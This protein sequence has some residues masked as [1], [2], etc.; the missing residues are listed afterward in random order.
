MKTKFQ[1]SRKII[2]VLLCVALLLSFVPLTA[3]AATGYVYPGGAGT[4]VADLDTANKYSESL[5]DNA[6]TEYAGR[7]WTDKSVYDSDVTFAT[8]GGGN[9]TIKLNENKNGEDFLVAYSALATSE[10]IEGQSQAPVDVVFVIDTS[11]S[12][13]DDMSSTDSTNRI[14]N[15]VSALNRAIETLMALNE[16]T[17]VGVVAF[18]STS[19]VL[20]ELGRYEKGTRTS[21]QG[22]N[23]TTVTNYFSLSSNNSTLYVHVKKEGETQQIDVSRSVTGGTNIQRGIYEGMNMLATEASTTAT[24]NGATVQRVPSLVLLSDGSPTYSSSSSSW[25]APANND[26]DGPGSGSYYGNGMK[27][28]MTGAYMKDAVDRHYGVEGTSMATTMYTIGIGITALEN[29]ASNFFNRYYTGEKDL[30]NITLNPK[31]HWNETNTMASDIRAAWNTYITNNGQPTV[32]TND[33]EQYTF[34]HPSAYDID[35]DADALKNLVDSYYDADNASAVT[36]VFE[37]IVASISVAAPQVPTEIKGTDPMTD[38]YITFTDPIGEYMEV[39]DVKAVIY[40]GTTFTVKNVAVNGNTTT[41]TFAG[42]VH[43][44]VYGDQNIQNILIT[45]TENAGKQTLVIKIPASVIPLR[46]N[47]VTLNAD[48]SVKTHTNNGAMPTRVIYSVGLQSEIVKES[49]DGE[50][51]IDRTKISSEYLDAHT[52]EDGTINFYTNVYTGEHVVHGYTA[53]N[54]T[55]EFEPSHT[56]KFYYIL[57][58]MPIYKDEQFTQQLPASEGIDPDT[59]YYY[60]DEFYHG[61]AVEVLPIARTGAQLTTTEIVTGSDGYLYRAVGSPRLNRILK[62][63]GTKVLNATETAEDFYAPTFVHDDTNPDPYEGKFVIYQ[64][65]NGV[66][67]LVAGGNLEISKTVLAAPGL[68]APDKAFTFAVNLNGAATLND[69]YD[70]VIVDAAGAEVGTGTLSAAN[71]TLSLKDGQKATIFNLP[72]DTAYEVTEQAEA[73]FTAQATGATGTVHANETDHAAFV[74][75]YNVTPVTYPAQ[76]SLMGKKVLNRPGNVWTADDVFTFYISPYNNAPLPIGYDAAA[77]VT[78]SGPDVAGGNTATFDFGS[79]QFTAPGVYRYTIYE[80]EPENHEYLPGMTYSRALYRAVITVVDN[81]D[82]TLSIAN[83][84]VQK[85]YTDD[86][87]ALFTYNANNQIVMNSGEEAQDDVVFVNTYNA[88]SVT[89]V[90]VA[91]KEY[92]DNSGQKPLVSGM[93]TFQLKALGYLDDAGNLVPDITNVPMPAGSVN[94]VITTHNEGHNVLFPAVEFTQSVIP[95][96]KT[97]ITFRYELSEVAGNVHGMTYDTTTYTADVIVSVDPT[98]HVLNVDA[99]YANVT[100]VPAFYNTYTPDPVSDSI[101]GSKLLIGRDMIAGESFT[102]TLGAN[103]ATSLA[104]RNG[105]IIVPSSVATVTGATDGNAKAFAFENIQ[106]KKAG[107]YVFTVTETAGTAGGLQYDDTLYTVTVVVDDTNDDGI[108]EIVSN[109]NDTQK[110]DFVNTYT[111]EY[112]GASVSLSGTKN[113]TGKS[114]LAGEFYFRVES[115]YNGSLTGRRFATHAADADADANGVY[116]GAITLLNEVTYTAAG[117]YEYVF[118]ELIPMDKV[119]GTTY[120]ESVYRYTVVVEDD[121]AGNLSVASTKLEKANGNAWAPAT[122]VV[123][124]NIYEP[125]AT[126]A[127]ML[128]IQKVIEGDRATALQAGEF[129]FEMTLQ[130]ADPSDGIILPAQTVVTNAANGDIIFDKLTFTKAGT[131]T[132]V[133]KE[134]IPAD[135]DKAPGI[136]YST[137]TIAATYRVTDDR[138]GTLTATLVEYVG[139]EFI[140]NEYDAAPGAATVEINKNFTGRENNAWLP[141]DQF[142]F[143]VKLDAATAEAVKN[144]DITVA[145]DAGS[146]DT[147]TKVI[148]T[149]GEVAAIDIQVNKIGSYRL[150]VTEK[151]NGI[152]G[153]TYDTQPRD[154][155]IVAEDDSANAQIVVTI[156]GQ[157]ANTLPLTFTNVYS[158]QASAPVSIT[159]HKDVTASAGNS[160]TLNAGDFQFTIEGSQGAPLPANTTVSNDAAGNVDFG[161]LTFTAA[162]TYVYTI[163]EV[164]GNDKGMTYDDAVYTVTVEVTDDP[165]TAQLQTVVTVTDQNGQPAEAVFENAYDPQDATAAIFGYKT[166]DSEHKTLAADEFEFVI[167]A[168]TQGAPLPTETTVKNAA[169]GSFHFGDI[170]F[171]QVG[172]YEYAITEKDLG[173]MGYTYDATT[174]AVTVVVT[175]DN[176][177]TLTATVTGVGTDANPTI[178]FV[179]GYEPTPVTVDLGLNGEL[180]KD[181]D[182]RE[183]KADEFEFAVLDAAGNEV[184]SAKNDANGLFAFALTF[185]KAAVYTFTIVEKDTALGGVAYDESVYGLEITVV[186]KGGYLEADKVVYTLENNEVT[187]VVFNNTYKAQDAEIVVEATKELTGRDLA[188]GEFSFVLKDEAGNEIETVTNAADGTIA[189]EKLAISKAGTYTYT[190]SEVTGELLYV[191]YDKAVY[192]VKVTVTDNLDGTFKVE[193]AY[194]EDGVAATEIVFQNSYDKPVPPPPVAPEAPQTGDHANL[195]LWFAL[196][197]VSGGMLFTALRGKKKAEEN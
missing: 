33:R 105:D 114:L 7:I 112:T 125:Q 3:F 133:V 27:A 143:E 181:L 197:F 178:R 22:N 104:I 30:A 157:A 106:F 176:E 31:D 146:E 32:D 194:A 192:T 177:G 60:L 102:F 83:A 173:A 51:Y 90:P 67:S 9:S 132:V 135:A 121:M 142:E 145:L 126:T 191:T 48:G 95:A 44:P 99:A 17:R 39:K 108:L 101:E 14:V 172:T 98:S 80:E 54:A 47:A 63:E 184:A 189:F 38:G 42:E 73:G 141:G 166:L 64:G 179:N 185:D 188:E 150:T 4:T 138:N 35:T 92:T 161:S 20:L 89:R 13:N 115:Y 183:L 193:Y 72:P 55:V 180:L 147:L 190:V 45:V 149:K 160:Y 195:G 165:T 28:L 129:S 12:M 97:S 62:F 37:Q 59:T 120:D 43:S 53:G 87:E 56:N 82:G 85:L 122:D 78:V 154:V 171:T 76:D 1:L 21:G 49:A 131:Y 169:D 88:D 153:I 100:R 61:N 8:F 113:L 140:I 84:D 10:S 162:G 41:Y 75:T 155:V 139:S 144:G 159:A 6:S 158:T 175:D 24:I 174:Y 130:A 152:A 116:S 71:N 118:R 36:D 16:H 137:Q 29:Y 96:G 57:E 148:D 151:H 109:S 68:T 168:V 2:S 117:T 91:L 167:A 163:R 50:L 46:V 93:F 187:G 196:M 94:G 103:A 70:Y 123:F 74:N 79:I 107:T 86:A 134:Q 186:D 164:Q 69:S 110:A 124:N 34:G 52:N 182:G 19:T 18:S 127:D 23:Q 119:G 26:N 77:G 15:T 136:T 65:N 156:N 5:G 25:W 170:T 111:T 81:G 11:G 58:D 40:A 128:L 66:L